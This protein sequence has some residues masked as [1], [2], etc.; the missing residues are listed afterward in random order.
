MRYIPATIGTLALVAVA[1]AAGCSN[2]QGNASA[3]DAGDRKEAAEQP[4]FET[5][6]IPDG[7]MVTVSL[8]TR[9]ST[10]SSHTGDAFVSTTVEPIRVGG[11]TVVP[12]GAKIHGVLR[13]VEASGRVQ[14]RAR[15]T[16]AY[17]TLVDPSGRTHP[18]SAVPLTLQAASATSS[19]VEKIAAGTVLGALIGGV[20]GGEKGAAI[21]AG[22]GAGAGTILMLATKGDEL[23]L[24][25]GQ[26]LSV[27]MISATSIQVLAQK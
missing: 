15:M 21:G 4:R 10:L 16:L 12:A 1:I 2:D 5:V 8:E 24:E 19:D 14:G 11:M 6:V 20:T 23:E 3:K 26:K 22:A 25:V 17:E 18:I 27:Q 13:D 7:S 9:L